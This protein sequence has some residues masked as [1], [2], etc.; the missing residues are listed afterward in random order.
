LSRLTPKTNQSK[1]AKKNTQTE[2]ASPFE[3][4]TGKVDMLLSQL[5]I[6][7][8]YEMTKEDLLDK[9]DTYKADLVRWEYKWEGMK[10]EGEAEDKLYGPFTVEEMTSWRTAGYFEPKEGEAPLVVRQ[11]VDGAHR[12]EFIP[13]GVVEFD[14][15]Y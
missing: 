5:G 11:L 15:L 9:L 8:I 14:R 3:I 10:D 1:R 2:A 6:A 7:Q 12:G 4:L 13:V